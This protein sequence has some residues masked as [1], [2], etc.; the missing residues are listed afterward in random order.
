MLELVN[1]LNHKMKEMGLVLGDMFRM[2]DNQY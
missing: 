2:A 1:N